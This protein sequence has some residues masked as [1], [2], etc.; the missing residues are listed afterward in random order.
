M[1]AVS[2]RILQR[3]ITIA[4]ADGAVGASWLAPDRPGRWPGVLFLS[5]IGGLRPG[6]TERASLL[7]A[8]GYAVLLPNAFYRNGSPPFFAPPINLNDE[9]TRRRFQELATALSGDAIDRDA[10]AYVREMEGQPLVQPGP[11]AVVGHCFTGAV[12][13]RMAAARPDAIAAVA[14]FHGGGL[15]TDSPNSPHLLLPRI[16]ARL[17]FGHAVSDPGMPADAIAALDRALA[18]WGGLFQSE[19]YEGAF[20]GWTMPSHPMYH[21]EQAARAFQRLTAFLSDALPHRS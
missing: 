19:L 15:F 8:A 5:D 16:T 20:H 14:S 10:D 21:P 6:I 13:L 9:A 4:S 3:D 17:Y 12:A 2:D 18:A 11:V 1:T 7:A